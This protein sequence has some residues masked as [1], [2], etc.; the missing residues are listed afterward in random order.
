MGWT[1]LKQNLVQF[2]GRLKQE[3]QVYRA[4]MADERT[5]WP[6]RM[7]LGAAVGY[8]ILPFDLIPDAIPV[9]GQLDDLLIVPGLFWL[10]LRLIPAEILDQARQQVQAETASG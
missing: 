4:V 1:N 8:L 2:T 3:L 6:A 5:P 7:L 9:L 10:A